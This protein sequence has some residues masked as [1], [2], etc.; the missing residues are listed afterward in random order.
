[1]IPTFPPVL[2][3]LWGD[4]S[5]KHL[6]SWRDLRTALGVPT[7]ARWV[8]NPTAV[9]QGAARHGFNPWPHAVDEGA[10]NTTAAAWIQSLAQEL[11]Y[12]VGVP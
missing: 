5:F 2:R 12:A 6:E 11:P 10:S 4:V 1:M 8:K 7:A 3:S 9:A